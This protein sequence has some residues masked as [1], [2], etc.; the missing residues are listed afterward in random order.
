MVI[1]FIFASYCLVFSL[2]GII[3]GAVVVVMR[4]VGLAI[5]YL[6][7]DW[8]APVLTRMLDEAGGISP[9][10]LTHVC[11]G[12]TWA[13]FYIVVVIWGK[14]TSKGLAENSESFNKINMLGGFFLGFVQAVLVFLI[15][16]YVISFV[17]NTIYEV[18][19]EARE[20]VMESLVLNFWADTPV[21]DLVMPGEMVDLVTLFKRLDNKVGLTSS[22]KNGKES[23]KDEAA[24][25]A[26]CRERRKR[27]MASKEARTIFEDQELM[28]TLK[29]GRLFEAMRHEKIRALYENPEVLYGLLEEL[30]GLFDDEC[31]LEETEPKKEEPAPK[32]KKSQKKKKKKRR[33]K[34]K[35]AE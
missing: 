2:L 30:R 11:F 13:V 34:K 21:A 14:H 18:R 16:M 12:V 35:E 20:W 5:G 10:T 23:K 27:L 7:A 17:K 24:R 25:L 8:I 33:S 3:S 29:S 1:D 22:D 32:K 15:T 4:I 9:E 6:L 19:P 28:E 26:S 31:S